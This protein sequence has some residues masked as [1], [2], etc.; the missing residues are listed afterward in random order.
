VAVARNEGVLVAYLPGSAMRLIADLRAGEAKIDARDAPIIAEAARS[1]LHT[2][3]ALRLA[4][5]PLDELNM[6]CGFDDDL[7]AHITQTSHRIRGLLAQIH[8]ALERV[9]EPRLEHPAVLDL[10]ERYPSPAKLAGTSKK[11]IANR[12][13]KLA[14]RMGKS[15]K[16]FSRSANRL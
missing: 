14:P 11:T 8:T 15:P 1:M 4:D 3:R 9:L 6:L 5:E 10:L 13:T 12:L 16:S 7:A 2:L